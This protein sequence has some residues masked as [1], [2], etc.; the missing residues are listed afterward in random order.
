[1]ERVILVLAMLAGLHLILSFLQVVLESIRNFFMRIPLQ[2]KVEEVVAD[3][4]EVRAEEHL[5]DW[6]QYDIPAYLRRSGIDNDSGNTAK[7][8]FEVIA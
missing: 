8:S 3:V 6:R 5:S 7:A 1:M 4:R 2:A